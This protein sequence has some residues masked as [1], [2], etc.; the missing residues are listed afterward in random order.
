MSVWAGPTATAVAHL[1]SLGRVGC[2][3]LWY[4]LVMGVLM[5]CAP[6]AKASWCGSWPTGLGWEKQLLFWL[7]GSE[8]PS[9]A[10]TP[11]AL[12]RPA[13]PGPPRGTPLTAS[14]PSGLG[15]GS[16]G[17]RQE[18]PKSFQA[19]RGGNA[20]KH[21]HDRRTKKSQSEAQDCLLQARP[22]TRTG[23][24]LSSR[25]GRGGGPHDRRAE[26]RDFSQVSEAGRSLSPSQ[27]TIKKFFFGQKQ[28]C[29]SFWSLETSSFCSAFPWECIRFSRPHPA[30]RATL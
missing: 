19:G 23:Q 22:Q 6:P 16:E 17:G 14:R 5:P 20:V 28:K 26:P 24:G 7:R 3:R 13:R 9:T 12:A 27:R 11:A 10:R 30:T 2:Q 4:F 25:A 8:W 15:P 1:G 21:L 29:R 18:A